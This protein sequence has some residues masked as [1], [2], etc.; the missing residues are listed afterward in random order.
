MS[1]AL[2]AFQSNPEIAPRTSPPL[3]P[4]LT[5]LASTHFSQ[6]VAVTTAPPRRAPR[7][8][9]PTKCTIPLPKPL[10]F[11]LRLESGKKEGKRF[12]FGIKL[13]LAQHD[14]CHRFSSK[15]QS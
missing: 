6:S 9:E 13:K 15:N 4:C 3:W 2:K 10:P 5:A 7:V 12:G 8:K 11:L 14:S 1:R